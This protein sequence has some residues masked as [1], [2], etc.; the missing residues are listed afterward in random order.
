MPFALLKVPDQESLV[1]LYDTKKATG[2]KVA[3]LLQTTQLIRSQKEQIICNVISEMLTKAKQKKFYG[4]ALVLL[5]YVFKSSSYPD[6][7]TEFD[8]I[9]SSDYFE[10]DIL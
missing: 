1:S 3:Q 6:L 10:M 9:L 5:L 4:S 2:K 7:R 8:N